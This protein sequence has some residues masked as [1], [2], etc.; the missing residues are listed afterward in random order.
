MRKLGQLGL[1]T[2]LVVVLNVFCLLKCAHSSHPAAHHT[3]HN[4][5]PHSQQRGSSRS[6]LSATGQASSDHAEVSVAPKLKPIVDLSAHLALP[7]NALEL[8]TPT[9]VS[10]PLAEQPVLS[11]GSAARAPGAPRGPPSNS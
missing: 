8:F 2:A 9:F 6:R 11:L 3:S 7:S 10:A 4:T 5:L 1:L